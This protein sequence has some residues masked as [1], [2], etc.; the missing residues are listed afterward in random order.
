MNEYGEIRDFTID[1]VATG[2]VQTS[3]TVLIS[4]VGITEMF[5]VTCCLAKLD[6]ILNEKV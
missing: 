1:F 3:I 2:R 4:L 6:L 5:M